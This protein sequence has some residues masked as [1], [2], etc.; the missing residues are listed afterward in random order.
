VSQATL[1]AKGQIWAND[2]MAEAHGTPTRG[3]VKAKNS[4]LVGESTEPVAPTGKFTSV[5]SPLSPPSKSACW[6]HHMPHN[7]ETTSGPPPGGLPANSAGPMTMRLSPA[8][9]SHTDNIS[10]R[11]VID[12]PSKG[13]LIQSARTNLRQ[14]LVKIELGRVIEVPDHSLPISTPGPSPASNA[15]RRPGVTWGSISRCKMTYRTPSAVR[16]ARR[17]TSCGPPSKPKLVCSSAR[18]RHSAARARKL[19]RRR[20]GLV[21]ARASGA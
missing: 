5:V 20:S 19:A 3:S 8:L 11:V 4:A 16:S 15:D 18:R 9:N 2:A 14:G 17:T 12:G 6:N 13:A 10:A 1:M 7:V 21:A